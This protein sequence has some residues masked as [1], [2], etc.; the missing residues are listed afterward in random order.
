MLHYE[1][2]ALYP[3]FCAVSSPC[4]LWVC[5]FF[6]CTGPLCNSFISLILQCLIT[7]Q[8]PNAALIF[9]WKGKRIS[10][11][12]CIVAESTQTCSSL[13]T[14]NVLCSLLMPL[15]VDTVFCWPKKNTCTSIL[16]WFA[17]LTGWWQCVFLSC[18]S[19]LHFQQMRLDELVDPI[20]VSWDMVRLITVLEIDNHSSFQIF[21]KT[22][23][24]QE[25]NFAWQLLTLL[26]PFAFFFQAN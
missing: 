8:L 6:S 16:L 22:F 21:V 20:V 19:F 4:V 10:A 7:K 1:V 25:N 2:S 12:H 3:E 23:E 24:Q 15:S 26:A 14:S 18:S 17:Y 5:V 13:R 11:G 9:L